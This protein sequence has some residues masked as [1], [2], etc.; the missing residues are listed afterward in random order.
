M[1]KRIGIFLS[2][3]CTFNLFALIIAWGQGVST[4]IVSPALLVNGIIS[5]CNHYLIIKKINK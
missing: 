3:F 5:L 1:K 2:V 4:N